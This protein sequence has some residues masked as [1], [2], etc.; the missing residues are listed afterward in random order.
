M[1]NDAAKSSK[2]T[3]SLRSKRLCLKTVVFDFDGTLV[4]LNI[5]FSQMRQAILDL[6]TGYHLPA[7]GLRDLFVLEMIDAGKTLIMQ[8]SPGKEAAFLREAYQRI[9]HIE[10]EAAKKGDLIAGTETMLRELQRRGITT[11]V[12][13]RNCMPSV[14]LAFPDIY[15]YCG[16]VV[17][18]EDTSQVK[19]H[20]EHLRMTLAK[21]HA[22]PGFSAMV[23]DHP[24]DIKIGKAAN[25]NTIGVLT[26]Y[27]RFEDLDN[28]G[29][30]VVLDKAADIIDLLDDPS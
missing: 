22:S 26:G 27:S 24:M 11:G 3:G 10:M 14:Q 8:H 2:K 12:V 28:A 9:A 13:T 19:P 29:A 21:L 4:R 15:R 17:T 5:N 23:G 20:P 16:A 7:D 25:I 1:T 18:R 30:D 6:M